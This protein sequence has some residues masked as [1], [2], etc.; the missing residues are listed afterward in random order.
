M[1]VL[2][3]CQKNPGQSDVLK[4]AQVTEAILSRK[5]MLTRPSKSFIQPLLRNP[6]ACS[7]CRDRAHIGEKVAHI[8]RLCFVQQIE[9]AIQVSLR[10]AESSHSDAPA[11]WVLG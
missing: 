7:Q 10:L 8:K 5:A 6:Y 1:V 2:V 4:L 11:I 9:C 3:A